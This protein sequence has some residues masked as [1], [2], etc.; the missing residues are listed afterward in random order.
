MLL[1]VYSGAYSR[2]LV[3]TGLA[4]MG[5]PSF[6]RATE[7]VEEELPHPRTLTFQ[8]FPKRQAHCLQNSVGTMAAHLPSAGHSRSVPY[9]HLIRSSS[10]SH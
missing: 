8:C 7:S 9:R 5:K 3:N 6:L 4:E 2:H 1:V 10:F